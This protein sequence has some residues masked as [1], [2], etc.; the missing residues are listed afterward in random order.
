MEFK[1]PFHPGNEDLLSYI[2]DLAFKRFLAK[3]MYVKH[4]YS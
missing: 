4:L 1:L 2:I 3:D